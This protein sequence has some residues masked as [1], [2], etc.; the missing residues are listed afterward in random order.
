MERTNRNGGC[1]FF[2][3]FTV[4]CFSFSVCAPNVTQHERKQQQI[5]WDLF[6]FIHQW[7]RVDEGISCFKKH[8]HGKQTSHV[9]GRGAHARENEKFV[10]SSIQGTERTPPKIPKRQPSP[11]SG[12]HARKKRNCICCTYVVW[13]D[14]WW[15]SVMDKWS[16]NTNVRQWKWQFISGGVPRIARNI[17]FVCTLWWMFAV[18]SAEKWTFGQCLP[19]TS[20]SIV[21]RCCVKMVVCE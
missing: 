18:P 10:I 1:L 13:G 20:V 19:V 6:P 8:R 2:F 14:G 16:I 21:C 17:S 4:N 15:W 9:Y 7:P 3:V 12:F 11:G 5:G